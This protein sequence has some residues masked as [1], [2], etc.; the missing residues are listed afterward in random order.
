M[1]VSQ[2]M[3][4]HKLGEF[5]ITRKRFTYKCVAS[6][7]YIAVRM[8]TGGGFVLQSDEE[9]VECYATLVHPVREAVYILSHCYRV[10]FLLSIS[11]SHATARA[12]STRRRLVHCVHQNL[13]A[14]ELGAG[15]VRPTNSS[16]LSQRPIQ[17]ASPQ[18]KSGILRWYEG[19]YAFTCTNANR[20][21]RSDRM[22]LDGPI[23][24]ARE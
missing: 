11:P 15:A 18:G 8:L 23:M 14:A 19:L 6:S 22:P 5:A 21:S 3:V 1:T 13:T 16:A 4:G 9:Q 2:D 20:L 17:Y 10:I 24:F 12:L 7:F